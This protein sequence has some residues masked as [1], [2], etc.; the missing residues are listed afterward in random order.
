MYGC[1]VGLG[2]VPSL[3]ARLPQIADMR[4]LHDVPVHRPLPLEDGSGPAQPG[5]RRGY[6]TTSQDWRPPS[7]N[8]PLAV[9]DNAAEQALDGYLRCLPGGIT[10]SGDY[11]FA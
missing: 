10:R 3:C 4:R 8:W 5:A 6:E 7:E 9:I 11:P 1:G 2:G